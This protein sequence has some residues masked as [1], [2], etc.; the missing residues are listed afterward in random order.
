[1]NFNVPLVF[2]GVLTSSLKRECLQRFTPGISIE[3]SYC[4]D[5]FLGAEKEHKNTCRAD[6][7]KNKAYH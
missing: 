7:V 2:S 4:C 1:M 5:G 3:S 6:N